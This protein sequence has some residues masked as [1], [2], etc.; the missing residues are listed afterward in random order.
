MDKEILN[1]TTGYEK[2]SWICM[3]VALFLVLKLH[4][5]LTVLSALLVFELVHILAPRL[6][7][8]TLKG[9]SARIAAVFVLSLFVVVTLAASIW[10]IAV[11]LGHESENIP[12]LLNKM[13]EI[14]TD[15]KS[16]LPDWMVSSLPADAADLEESIVSWLRNHA[17][18]LQSAGKEAG[19]AFAHLV[20]GVALGVMLALKSVAP[21][22][23][24]RPLAKAWVERITLFGDSFRAI[25]FAQV[26]ISAINTVF[27]TIYLT[28]ILPLFGIHLPFVPIMIATTFFAGL[29]PVVGNIISNTIIVVVSLSHSLAAA[30]ASIVFLVFIHKLE[31]FLNARII[32][33]RIKAQAWELLAAMFVMEAAF[34]ME[35]V[36]AA[37]IYYAYIKSEL[38]KLELV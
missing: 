14:I 6:K 31:Y 29:I 26:R 22:H 4:L 1:R 28:I 15:Y 9:Y 16:K 12:A 20:I 35:G 23:E 27:T 36:I 2:A 30:V 38:V 18:E 3:A 34:G 19:L 11:F 32:G 33:D 24:Y 21:G 10:G 5:L 25:V 37:P 8:T 7:F 13:A 17:R